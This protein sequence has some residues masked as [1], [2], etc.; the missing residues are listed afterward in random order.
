MFNVDH[1]AISISN[2]DESCNFYKK[3]GF[4]TIKDWTA[5]DNSLRIIHMDNGGFVLEMFC[6]KKHEDLP[7]FVEFLGTDLQ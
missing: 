4:K 1:Y 6:Y 3:L 7:K 2:A 5:D